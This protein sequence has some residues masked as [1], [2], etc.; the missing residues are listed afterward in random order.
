MSAEIQ[1]IIVNFNAGETL[2]RCVQSVLSSREK[3]SITVVD[4]ASVDGSTEEIQSLFGQLENVEILCNDKNIGFSRAVNT[5]ARL[6]DEELLLILN[7]DCELLSGA[8]GYLQQALEHDPLAALS[9]PTVVDRAGVV[10]KGTLRRFPDP[11]NSL[12]T[13]TGLWRLG[14]WFP[15]FK[16]VNRHHSSLPDSNT[17][18]EAV[19]GACMLVRRK[20]FEDAGSMDEGYGL[21]GEDLDLMY[22]LQQQGNHCVFVPAARVFHQQG[23]SSRS[24][25]LWVHRQKHLGMQRFFHKFQAQRYPLP[26]RWLVIAGIWLRYLLTL[27]RVLLRN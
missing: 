24:R 17:T 27:P 9:G 12:V 18:V 7:P 6:G 26:V 15:A 20:A 5:A 4:N 23:V 14:R 19:S 22:R 16:G 3:V 21:H 1:V 8:L 2:S 25:P 11:W 13:L 10:Q